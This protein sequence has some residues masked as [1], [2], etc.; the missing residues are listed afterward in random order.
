MRTLKK[1]A[2][3]RTAAS[4]AKRSVVA[5]KPTS[6]KRSA[7]K[8][9]AKTKRVAGRSG[10]K[11]GAPVGAARVPAKQPAVPAA[12]SQ[13][14]IQF[15]EE[16]PVPKTHLRAKQLRGFRDMLSRKRAELVRDVSRMSREALNTGGAAHGDRSSMPIHMAD[17]G[18]DNWETE[19]TL[20][21]VQNERDLVLEIDDALE[22][23][24]NKTYG[25]CVATHRPISDARLLAKPWAKYCIEY[26]RAR[27]EGRAI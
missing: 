7:A 17:I 3:K 5:P 9:T 1:Q 8:G 20:G 27:E 10:D 19:F 11:K 23:I 21:L 26:A 12:T 18:S 15:V 25:V 16:R 6:A 14:P 22:R 13:D 4:V 2:V 24:E